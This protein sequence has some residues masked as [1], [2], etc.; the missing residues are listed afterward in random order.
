MTG[1]LRIKM[2]NEFSLSLKNLKKLTSQE[3]K[4][5]DNGAISSSHLVHVSDYTDKDR[6]IEE[7]NS[8]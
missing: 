3:D 4:N 6:S 7:M 5:G 8:S 1:K 2:F